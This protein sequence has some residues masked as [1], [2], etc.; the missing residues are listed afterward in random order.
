MI[1]V[2]FLFLE[3]T[4]LSVRSCFGP[5]KL[6]IIPGIVVVQF[7]IIHFIG[8]IFRRFIFKEIIFRKVFIRRQQVA[9]FFL[10]V[11]GEF[12][13]ATGHDVVVANGALVMAVHEHH[14]A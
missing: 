14:F 3:E 13:F 8:C 6:R 2:A 4:H 5:R 7:F 1:R 10:Q 11:I 12:T 9:P